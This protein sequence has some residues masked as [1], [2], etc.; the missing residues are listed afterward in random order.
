MF[1]LPVGGCRKKNRPK[2]FEMKMKQAK[3]P[4]M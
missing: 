3:P 2:R 1:G 4:M